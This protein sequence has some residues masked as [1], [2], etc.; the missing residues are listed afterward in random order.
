MFSMIVELA[1]HHYFSR[2][3]YRRI[4][5]PK[6]A[7]SCARY[8]RGK[9]HQSLQKSRGWRTDVSHESIKG[10][11][12][13][14]ISIPRGCC[15]RQT[16]PPFRFVAIHWQDYNFSTDQVERANFE[17]L[18]RVCHLPDNLSDSSLQWQRYKISDVLTCSFRLPFLVWFLTPSQMR[19]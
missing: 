13:R 6:N 17:H 11:L 12:V 9:N 10:N 14:T 19:N 5:I 8:Q 16:T 4:N 2:R 3:K 18:A 7:L 1:K 15:L